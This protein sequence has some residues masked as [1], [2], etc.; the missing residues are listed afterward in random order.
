MINRIVAPKIA[1]EHK[2][3]DYGHKFRPDYFDF[4]I[5]CPVCGSKNVRV[6]WFDLA[7]DIV[8]Y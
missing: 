4:D 7:L 2:C 1:R 6:V 3:K 8:Q 5:K